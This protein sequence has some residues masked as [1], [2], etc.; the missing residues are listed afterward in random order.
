MARPKRFELLAYRFVAC[1]SIQLSYERV[2]MYLNESPPPVKHAGL[3]SL[4]DGEYGQP[5]RL[6]RFARQRPIVPQEKPSPS[7][8]PFPHRVTSFLFSLYRPPGSSPSP[9]ALTVAMRP[10]C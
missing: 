5:L 6:S 8:S 2:R 9:V 7:V 10:I 1:C 4:R 3:I